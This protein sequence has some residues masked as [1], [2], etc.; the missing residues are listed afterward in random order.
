MRLGQTT[1]LAARARLF[2]SRKGTIISASCNFSARPF[3]YG[4]GPSEKEEGE[5]IK[6]ISGVFEKGQSP[7]LTT[8]I[9]RLRQ[10]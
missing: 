6:Y 8:I 3:P 4:V 2:L 5:R 9:T 7:N 1:L 10:A